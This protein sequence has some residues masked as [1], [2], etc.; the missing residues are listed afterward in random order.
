M[1]FRLPTNDE[2]AGYVRHQFDRIARKYDLT[3]DAISIGMHRLWKREAIAS[4]SIKADGK[5]LDVCCGTGDLS[6][7]LARKLSSG[8][9]V[10]GLDFSEQ[11][12]EAAKRRETGKAHRKLHGK[13]EW[14]IGDAQNLPFPDDSFEGAINSFGLRNLTDLQAGI[15]EMSRVVRPGGHVVNLDLGHSQ[16][17][18]FSPLFRFYFRNVVPLIGQFL[19]NDKSA[20]TYL[21]E[22]L[23]TY[24]RP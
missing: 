19:Q 8:G 7:L 2:K 4:L 11:M 3:N 23:N 9:S 16:I 14:M 17:P 15:N 1:P 6:L 5:Y 10:V 21:P 12:L 18:L 20:Y 22:S 13:I 24:P